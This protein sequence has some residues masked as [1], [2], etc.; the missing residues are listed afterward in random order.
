METSDALT[1]ARQLLK[2][3]GLENVPVILDNAKNRRGICR[4][5]FNG[6]KEIGLSRYFIGLNDESKVRNTILHEIAHALT[7]GH[8]HDR[9]WRRKAIEIGCTGERSSSNVERQPGRY[10]TTC[11]GKTHH[12]HRKGKHFNNY[13]CARCKKGLTFVDTYAVA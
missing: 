9:V 1:L 8:H 5:S 13:R 7:P 11:C 3:H 10:Q 6:V 2:L 12:L 4:Y